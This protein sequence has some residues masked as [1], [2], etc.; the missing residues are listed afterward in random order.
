M[1]IL[2]NAS[3]AQVAGVYL[4]TVTDVS[5]GFNANALTPILVTEAGI[6]TLSR[7]LQLQNAE[8]SIVV[9]ELGMLTVVIPLHNLNV[10]ASI[11][12]IP[13]PKAM[14]VTFEHPKKAAGPIV[15]T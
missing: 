1:F 12:V 3:S 14:E 2:L 11:V 10:F 15:V 8:F 13:L 9:T 7:L 6:I 5:F 4:P